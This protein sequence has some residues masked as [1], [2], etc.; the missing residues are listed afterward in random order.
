VSSDLPTCG[1]LTMMV[2]CSAWSL[3]DRRCVRDAERDAPR[4]FFDFG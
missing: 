3:V 1:A 2:S 4:K